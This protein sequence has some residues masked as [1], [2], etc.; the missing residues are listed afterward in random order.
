MGRGPEI[1]TRR[2]RL[3]RWRKDDLLSFV[4]L[5]ADPV[6]MEHMPGVLNQSQ[7][8]ELMARFEYEFEESGY[9]LWAVEVIWARAF[10]GFCGLAKVSFEAHFTPAVEVG[11]RIA[12]DHW[13]NGYASE[14]AGAALE[15]A[16]N[17]AGLDEV[18][19][20]TVPDNE[21]STRVM[22]RLGMTHDP[23]DDFD[24][25]L[26]SEGDLL[27]HHVLYR[28]DAE[29]W[30]ASGRRWLVPPIGSGPE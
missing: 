29:R 4:A 6:V 8:A 9:G 27:R 3:R 14:A 1:E 30:V 18:V 10:I 17:T 15:F 28:I 26:L 23:A 12:K 5:N 11:W 16:F 22:E 7:S 21:R 20:F 19:S 13:G 2:L 25:P 24:H